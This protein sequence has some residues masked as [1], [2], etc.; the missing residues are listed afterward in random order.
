MAQTCEAK[1][2]VGVHYAAFRC[3]DA[4]QTIWFYRDVLGLAGP[5]EFTEA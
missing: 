4:E 1:P 5:T 2:V 3:R